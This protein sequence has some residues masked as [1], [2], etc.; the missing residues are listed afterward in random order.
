MALVLVACAP[1][2]AAP[3]SLTS[4]S[5]S[6]DPRFTSAVREAA[7]QYQTWGRVDDQPRLAPALCAAPFG[8]PQPSHIRLSAAGAGPHHN[9][10]YFLWASDRDLYLNHQPPGPGFAVVKEAFAAVLAPTVGASAA[11]PARTL[12]TSAGQHLAAGERRDLF[13]MTKLAESDGTDEGW[14]YGTVAVD[15][16]VTSAGRVAECMGCHDANGT[17]GRLFGLAAEPG[18]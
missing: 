8:G 7:R 5:A 11:D 12:V 9:K 15:G 6:I 1:A 3:A 14:V 18:R 10:L 4:A 13:V 16:R 17:Q 2:P